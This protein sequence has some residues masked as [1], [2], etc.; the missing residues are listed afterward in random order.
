MFQSLSLHVFLFFMVFH[1]FLYFPATGAAP[2]PKKFFFASLHPRD[3]VQSDHEPKKNF[4]GLSVPQR[5]FLVMAANWPG[6]PGQPDH[7]SLPSHTT[8]NCR[9]AAALPTAATVGS[10]GGFAADCSGHRCLRLCCGFGEVGKTCDWLGGNGSCRL[11]SKSVG[12]CRPV[13]TV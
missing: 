5:C 3:F 13:A 2:E 1:C 10:D 12:L 8:H 9:V 11:T 4:S 6:Q 7:P